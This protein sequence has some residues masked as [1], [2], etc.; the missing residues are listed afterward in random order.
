MNSGLIFEW[1]ERKRRNNLRKHKLDF[2]DCPL[3]FSGPIVTN[4]DDRRDYG[5]VRFLTRGLL[6]GR[7]VVVA[8]T[9][10]ADVVRIISMRKAASHEQADYFEKTFEK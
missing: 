4:L 2:A 1:D 9:E 6:R 5:E 7:V 8:H 3:V 10:E